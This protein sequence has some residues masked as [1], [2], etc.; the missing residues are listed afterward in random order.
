MSHHAGKVFL[1]LNDLGLML[2]PRRSR[3]MRKPRSHSYSRLGSIAVSILVDAKDF[4]KR[5]SASLRSTVSG[6]EVDTSVKV[7]APFIPS[8]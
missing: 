4:H 1:N 3:R 5:K 2:C 7:P 8:A 6:N